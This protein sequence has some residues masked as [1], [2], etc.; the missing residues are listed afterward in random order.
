MRCPLLAIV[1]RDFVN[2]DVPKMLPDVSASDLCVVLRYVILVQVLLYRDKSQHAAVVR[3]PAAAAGCRCLPCIVTLSL[4]SWVIFLRI[5]WCI[6]ATL[7]LGGLIRHP[8]HPLTTLLNICSVTMM[9]VDAYHK[10]YS[11]TWWASMCDC[12]LVFLC[13]PLLGKPAHTVSD[14]CPCRTR[15]QLQQLLHQR[16]RLLC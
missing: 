11:C 2:A 9:I 5:G 13:A 15:R 8:V 7:A 10:L 16:E 3:T 14:L 12:R 1:G 6:V 4:P